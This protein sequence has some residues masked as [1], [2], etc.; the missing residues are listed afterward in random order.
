MTRAL[1]QASHL[2]D[3]LPDLA[4]FVTEVTARV[5]AGAWAR[6]AAG[7]DEPPGGGTPAPGGRRRLRGT[8][9]VR[10]WGARAPDRIHVASWTGP[11]PLAASSG[12][13]IRRRL[14]RAGTAG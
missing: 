11:A 5:N 7:A 2:P 4:R 3:D 9:R 12:D 13:R 6:F 1:R 8:Q 14:S 10:V